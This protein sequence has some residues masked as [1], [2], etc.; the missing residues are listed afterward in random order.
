[1]E[2][3]VAGLMKR[4]SDN[5]LSATYHWVTG[6]PE[7]AISVCQSEC[8]Q[9]IYMHKSSLIACTTPPAQKVGPDIPCSHTQFYLKTSIV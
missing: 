8:D 2:D 6:L 1:M 9:F 7:L 3:S 5:L 4:W